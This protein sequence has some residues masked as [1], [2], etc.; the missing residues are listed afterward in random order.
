MIYII[1]LNWNNYHDTGSCIDSLLQIK[2]PEFRFL[3]VDNASTDDSYSN[4]IKHLTNISNSSYV[5]VAEDELDNTPL[6]ADVKATVIKANK[7]H[8]YGGGNNLGLQYAMAQS[9]C[10]Y[11]WVLNNDTEVDPNSLNILVERMQSDKQI[12]IC[13]SRLVYYYER[14]KLQGLGGKYNKWLCTTKHHRAF[15]LAVQR[16]NDEDES[17]SID[18]VIGASLFM[19]KELIQNVGYFDNDYFLY[20]EE[21]DLCKRAKRAGFK[22]AVAS[23]SIVFHKEGASINAQRSTFSEFHV[24]RSKKIFISKNYPKYQACLKLNFLIM[25]LNRLRRRE[26]EKAGQVLKYGVLGRKSD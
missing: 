9:D 25:L 4:I 19:S 11:M 23:D 18:Y 8:G 15:N 10:E 6:H 22:I 1:L 3:I 5:E 13:G 20:F 24:I 17:Q 2:K 26:W 16:F 12:G 7:N 14:D 21:L